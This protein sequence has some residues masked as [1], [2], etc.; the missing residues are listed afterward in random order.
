MLLGWQQVEVRRGLGGGVTCWGSG[1]RGWWMR[2][3][4]DGEQR[5]AWRMRL[6]LWGSSTCSIGSCTPKDACL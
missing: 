3:V 1:C 4:A 6:M 5:H 2:C